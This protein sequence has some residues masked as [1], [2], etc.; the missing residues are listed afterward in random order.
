VT[1]LG[2]YS[3][4]HRLIGG[5]EPEP[6]PDSRACWSGKNNGRGNRIHVRM[7]LGSRCVIKANHTSAKVGHRARTV[8]GADTPRPTRRAQSGSGMERLGGV[9]ELVDGTDYANLRR[10]YAR[11]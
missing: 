8:G 4:Q 3:P 7:V 1:E 5:S 11:P 10:I 2:A 9:N 6:G